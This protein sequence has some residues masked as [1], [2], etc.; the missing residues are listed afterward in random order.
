MKLYDFE[1]MSFRKKVESFVRRLMPKQ[2]KIFDSVIG[3][4]LVPMM[5]YFAFS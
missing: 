1:T 3:R 4:V 5:Y 2:A